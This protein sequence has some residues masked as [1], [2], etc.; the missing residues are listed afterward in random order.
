MV[1]KKKVSES[2]PKKKPSPKKQKPTT[3][4]APVTEPSFSFYTLWKR[5]DWAEQSAAAIREFGYEAKVVKQFRACDGVAYYQV[6]T[7]PAV[8]VENGKIK[9]V[10]KNGADNR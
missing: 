1:A 9:K 2:T 10:P 8:T 3:V 5:E 6:H 7:S 4:T